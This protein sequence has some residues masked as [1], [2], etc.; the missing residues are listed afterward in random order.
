MGILMNRFEN[1]IYN[2]LEAEER[3]FDEMRPKSIGAYNQRMVEHM[4]NIAD[5]EERIAVEKALLK[6]SRRQFKSAVNGMA[7]D[8]GLEPVYYEED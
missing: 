3:F 1:N 2:A 8:Q 6:F 5:L 7:Y 4:V